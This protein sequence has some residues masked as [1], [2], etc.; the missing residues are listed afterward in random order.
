MNHVYFALLLICFG[1]LY[2]ALGRVKRKTTF[3]LKMILLI[4]SSAICFVYY[5]MNNINLFN[6]RETF[7]FVGM[8][9]LMVTYIL[10]LALIIIIFILTF[11]N[12]RNNFQ[13][14]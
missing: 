1:V 9:L 5:K 4:A 13:G 6:D 2:L 3:D 14:R 8:Y 7:M 10:A 12:I 11:T